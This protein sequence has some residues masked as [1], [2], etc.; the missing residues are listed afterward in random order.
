MAVDQRAIS[1][2]SRLKQAQTPGRSF[3]EQQP[4]D[5][6]KC[7][8]FNKLWRHFASLETFSTPRKIES[9]NYILG[10]NL[11]VTSKDVVKILMPTVAAVV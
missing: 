4:Y 8:M 1:S 10:A 6:V 7:K 2:L 5:W 9:Q 11:G 3:N